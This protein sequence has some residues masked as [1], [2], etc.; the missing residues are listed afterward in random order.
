MMFQVFGNAA[1]PA[2]RPEKSSHI[3]ELASTDTQIDAPEDASFRLEKELAV[4]LARKPKHRKMP[5]AFAADHDDE[6]PLLQ[7][8]EGG[9]RPPV[10]VAETATRAKSGDDV[11][12][13]APGLDSASSVET[14]TNADSETRDRWMKSTRRSRRSNLFRKTA[15]VA[16]TLAVTAFIISIVAAILFGLPDGFK[17]LIASNAR[18]AAIA[19]KLDAAIPAEPVP[20]RLRWVSN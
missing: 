6:A 19:G 14:V 7:A 1:K 20:V 3:G 17:N 9:D 8:D 4:L 10:Q 15:S 5:T 2:E 11:V 12:G 16:I 13:E 18:T